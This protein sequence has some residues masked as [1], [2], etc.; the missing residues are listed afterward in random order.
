MLN[1]LFTVRAFAL[2][3]FVRPP[4]VDEIEEVAT[5][6]LPHMGDDSLITLYGLQKE[7]ENLKCEEGIRGL[8]S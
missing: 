7:G 6:T 5:K 3:R 1:S 2:W 8:P 4:S